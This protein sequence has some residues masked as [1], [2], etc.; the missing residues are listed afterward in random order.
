MFSSAGVGDSPVKGILKKAAGV[1]S[2]AGLAEDGCALLCNV[3]EH[4]DLVS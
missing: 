1:L 2:E 4:H 3:P